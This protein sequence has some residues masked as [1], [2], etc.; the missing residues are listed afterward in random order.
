MKKA[1]LG[2]A[3]LAVFLM[4]SAVFSFAQ[5][6]PEQYKQR[7]K[8]KQH[9]AMLEKQLNKVSGIQKV[10][11]LLDL[12]TLYHSRDPDKLT[13]YA[14]QAMR[15][16]IELGYRQGENQSYVFLSW[17][18][19]KLGLYR[20]ALRYGEIALKNA[21]KKRDKRVT[22]L[23]LNTLGC[24]YRDMGN[25][26]K[27]LKNHL[28]ALKIRRE[29]GE[30]K[31]FI[32]E[33]VLNIGDVYSS[34]GD[35]DKALAYTLEA[36]KIFEEAGEKPGI[37][38]SLA[39]T[40]IV[41]FSLGKYQKALEYN[42]KSM[43]LQKETGNKH[44]ISECL[45][46][47]GMIYAGLKQYDKALAYY[48]DAL[49]LVEELRDGKTR[50]AVLNNIGEVYNALND[51]EKALIYQDKARQT[52]QPQNDRY[53]IAQSLMLTADV[54]L[55]M[56]DYKKAMQYLAKSLKLAR[57]IKDKSLLRNIHL[58]SYRMYTGLG[59][60]KK[61]L[62]AYRYFHQ[63]DKAL[64]DEKSSHQINEL[65][66][67]YETEKKEKEIQGLK[68]DNE[69]KQ[70]RL[71]NAN[72]T[73]NALITGLIL[74]LII[75]VLLFRKYL[76]LFAFWKKQKYIGQFRLMEKIGTGAMGT[77]YK[78][79]SIMKKSDMAA[80]KVLKE[81]LFTDKTGKS[82]FKREA[83]IIDKLDHPHIIRIFQ[84]GQYK[85][86][87][88]IAMEFLQGKTLDQRLKEGSQLTIRECLH[89][90]IQISDAF[91]FIHGKNIIHRD[92][93][94]SNIMLVPTNGDPN[95]VKILD[96][97]LA[98]MEFQTQLTQSGNFLGTLAYM[99]PEQLLHADS[100]PAND[101]FS[102]GVTFYYMLCG[103]VPFPGQTVIDIMRE[104]INKK[105]ADVSTLRTDIPDN[106]NHLVMSMMAKQPAQRPSVESVLDTLYQLYRY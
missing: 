51:Y 67:K 14:Y 43:K 31:L 87:L 52:R 102:M 70:L 82:R 6:T 16:S 15:L 10:E 93:K 20:E 46:G 85:Q 63:A 104:I 7:D 78:A 90:M 77:V 98:K 69:I 9:I 26:D 3:A 2:A 79:H 89:I 25:L 8:A 81:E 40:A 80:V 17:G 34:A 44:G 74:V 24:I 28:K 76:Y 83:A 48:T 72:I 18:C 38:A 47:F 21:E 106:L 101:I 4:G 86:Q 45:L 68:K 49:K 13:K 99:S 41:Y 50:A 62:N 32:A 12:A 94:P 55:G 96:F 91:V 97:G 60:Y 11:V 105:P 5:L 61:A 100:S 65:Q 42:E 73:R 19:F 39:K 36:A 59:D 30:K 64:L 22:A 1:M 103:Q 88:F 58:L 33:S 92:L 53:S 29:I 75:L 84:R 37:A 54:Y 95:F 35:L 27:G 23:C 66:I 57:N 56:K 71:S